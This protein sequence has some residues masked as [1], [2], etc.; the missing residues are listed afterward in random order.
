MRRH[1]MLLSALVVLATACSGSEP[2]P[3]VASL[4]A[5]STDRGGTAIPM[6]PVD[7]E[8]ARL[9]FAACMRDQGLDFP[10]PTV[11]SAGNISFERPRGDGPPDA[12]E[13]AARREAFSA[14]GDLLAGT[15]LGFR[16]SDRTDLED[17]LVE[18]AACVR[19]N[20]YDMPDPDFSN[21]GPGARPLGEV[22]RTD[23]DFRK[24]QEACRDVLA[25]FG[26]GGSFRRP[27]G[28]G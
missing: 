18:F 12:E 19:D 10:D 27:A 5:P 6:D 16:G 20:G 25:G 7:G 15:T 26:P 8:Q 14:C 1:F 9:D 24:A 4:S 28:D 3:G 22:D 23:P 17:R 13:R 21:S 11:D 2:N